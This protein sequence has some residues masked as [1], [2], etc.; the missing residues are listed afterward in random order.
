MEILGF[1]SSGRS[2]RR[3]SSLEYCLEE[4]TVAGAWRASAQSMDA[5]GVRW[6]LV[7]NTA[8]QGPGGLSTILY[9]EILLGVP[10]KP[11]TQASPP[12]GQASRERV[13]T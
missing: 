7:T 3:R 6:A 13:P 9:Y 1:T 12:G 4:S 5:L 2:W 8:F 10:L 11:L